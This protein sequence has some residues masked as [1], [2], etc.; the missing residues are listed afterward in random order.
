MSPARQDLRAEPRVPPQRPYSAELPG[1]PHTENVCLLKMLLPD[2]KGSS[3]AATCSAAAAPPDGIGWDRV[4]SAGI[5]SD[6]KGCVSSSIPLSCCLL[7]P[8]TVPPAHP[9]SGRRVPV[10]PHLCHRGK[11]KTWFILFNGLTAQAVRAE[12]RVLSLRG[13]GRLWWFPRLQ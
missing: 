5:A 4:G 11:T 8:G 7:P 1:P 10:M 6:R 12:S 2:T 9:G 13:R 3:R